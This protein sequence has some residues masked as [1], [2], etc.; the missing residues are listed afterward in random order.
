MK[1][2]EMAPTRPTT[3]K[4]SADAAAMTDAAPEERLVKISVR[5]AASFRRRFRMLATE[6]DCEMQDMVV[7]A[8]C[9]TFPELREA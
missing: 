5:V 7:E 8:L 9:A 4:L 2:A 1:L 3:R 6:R